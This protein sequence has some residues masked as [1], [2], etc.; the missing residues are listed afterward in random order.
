MK[1]TAS[2]VLFFLVASV[3][4]SPMAAPEDAGSQYGNP[5]EPQIQNK[6]LSLN[7]DVS[8]QACGDWGYVY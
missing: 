3:V 7:S 4:A 1:F 8:G 5:R 6:G 2:S